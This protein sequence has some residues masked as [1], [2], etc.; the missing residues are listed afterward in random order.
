MKQLYYTLLIFSFLFFLSGCVNDPDMDTRLQ[1]ASAPEV[2]NI[3]IQDS[4]A[5]TIRVKAVVK[6]ENGA[7]L[8]ER[9]FRYWEKDEEN[10][11]KEVLDP[12]EDLGKGEYSI[13]IKGLI[14]GLIYHITPFASNEKG[15]AYGD[16]IKVN[17]TP[18]VGSLKTLEVDSTKTKATS[19][20][21]EGVITDPGEGALVDYGFYLFID[22]DT[23]ATF[24]K[25]NNDE[26]QQI[27]DTIY[28]CTIT[29]NLKPE[30]TYSVEFFAKNSFG[31]F[32]NTTGKKSFKTTNGRPILADTVGYESNFDFV[33]LRSTLISGGDSEVEEVGFCWSKDK[34]DK[35]TVEDHNT[36]PCTLEPDSTFV[37]Q[38][39]DMEASTNYYVRAYAI[40]SFGVS[41]SDSTINVV[42]KR[43]LPTIFLNDSKTYT[44]EN[45]IVTVS[46]ELKDRGKY[47]EITSLM[48]YYSSSNT[49][50]GPLANEGEKSFTLGEDGKSFNIPLRLKGGLTYYVKVY[51]ESKAG[52][53]SNEG[54]YSFK[55]PNVYNALT[56]FN[57]GGRQEFNMF[58][59][60]NQIFVLGGKMGGQYTN[61]LFG[62]S[63]GTWAKLA[64]YVLDNV[65]GASVCVYN[66][67]AYVIGGMVNQAV[68]QEVYFYNYDRWTQRPL[69]T[70]VDDMAGIINRA[71]FTYN[72]SIV[73][74]GG[75]KKSTENN[76]T[77]ITQDSI[78]YWEDG[79]WQDGGNFWMPIK[80]GVAVTTGDS[81][82]FGL[83]SSEDGSVNRRLWLNSSN[84]W[85]DGWNELSSA[86]DGIGR[87]S[88]GVAKGSCLYFIDNA[89]I[90]WMYNTDNKKWYK[91]SKLPWTEVTPD[92]RM[93]VLDDVIYILAINAYGKSSFVTYDPIWDMTIE[94]ENE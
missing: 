58:C 35:P 48:L 17:T 16:T 53:A 80:N 81:V 24:C 37:G 31:E 29:T 46:G 41:Y 56:A 45:G 76:G 7:P 89:G 15:R 87:V 25:K 43:D 47:E 92:Y 85:V 20:Y 6:T 64:P 52:I 72:N 68:Q 69:M 30:T 8:T 18:G 39:T 75:E 59:V 19:A 50:P 74:I 88:S 78:N 40:N 83:G 71:S 66:N 90:I 34:E 12:T 3:E 23:I 67:S 36:I 60:E 73:L 49:S 9:G 2:G 57:G 91:C 13:Q 33:S 51:A 70:L 55:T 94:Q 32:T 10:N 5:T 79:L 77:W 22:K 84:D 42:K 21:V 62:Y 54:V 28:A 93:L 82:F 63:S 65:Y 44:I 61:E 86:P 27:K 4:T 1:N 26:I 14:N 11:A 38:L